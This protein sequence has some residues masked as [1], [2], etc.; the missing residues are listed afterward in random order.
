MFAWEAGGKS[1]CIVGS[2][3]FTSAAF[4]GRN[5]EAC[6]VIQNSSELVSQL[7]DSDLIKSQSHLAIFHQG[8]RSHQNQ[9]MPEAEA[10]RLHYAVLLDQQRIRISFHIRAELIGIAEVSNSIAGETQPRKMLKLRCVKASTETLI[11]PEHTL[12]DCN[13]T[14]LASLIAELTAASA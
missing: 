5:G 13:G 2:A 6:L 8:A 4:D 12:A 10:L 3:N 14:I 1:G 9:K 7:F 11:L